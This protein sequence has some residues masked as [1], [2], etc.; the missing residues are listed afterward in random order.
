VTETLNSRLHDIAATQQ[1]IG[2]HRSFTSIPQGFSLVV[3]GRRLLKQG[4]FSP[5]LRL[6]VFGLTRRGWIAGDL[7][8]VCRRKA[9]DR[10]FWL[11]SDVLVYGTTSTTNALSA[12]K[13]MVS[14]STWMGLNT[15]PAPRSTSMDFKDHARP[16]VPT[17]DPA[18]D[19]G[20]Y[21]F[22]RQI[23]LDELTVVATGDGRKK[24][25]A[26]EL[27]SPEKSFAVNACESLSLRSR[28]SNH[29]CLH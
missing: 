10:T 22:H 8:K 1:L 6:K 24:E 5:P 4:P 16:A 7:S 17:L 12:S 26:F 3:P 14:I 29:P 15:V 23:R 20:R 25:H 27:L 2:L 11:F 19:K 28:S 18:G 21:T 9:E 13:S